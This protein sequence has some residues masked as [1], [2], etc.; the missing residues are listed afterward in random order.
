MQ[1]KENCHIHD[2]LNE[3]CLSFRKGK[4]KPFDILKKDTTRKFVEIFIS[5]GD[6][7]EDVDAEV[8]SEFV[9]RMY[10]QHKTQDVNEARY[11]KVLEMTGKVHQVN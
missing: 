1:K 11:N 7:T 2:N 9:C 3:I 4:V 10:A 6:I 5:M 8:A